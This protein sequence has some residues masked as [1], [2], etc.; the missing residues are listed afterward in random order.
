MCCFSRP[1]KSVTQTKIFARFLTK[2]EQSL[3]YQMRL[4]TP[5]DVAMILP[6]PVIKGSGEGS[7]KFIDL[8]GYQDFFKSLDQ[9]FAQGWGNAAPRGVYKREIRG[10]QKNIDILAQ[11]VAIGG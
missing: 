6:I 10:L 9:G 1:V 8:S 2:Q 4:D 3:V 5:E 11:P 7:V